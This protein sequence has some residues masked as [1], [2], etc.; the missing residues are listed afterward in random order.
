M[1]GLRGEDR[2]KGVSL[3][4]SM[5][6][7]GM[8]GEEKGDRGSRGREGGQGRQQ[9]RQGGKDQRGAMRGRRDG[10]VGCWCFT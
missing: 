9:G 10:A 5:S 4:L 6:R 2:A 7:N 3:A 1:W 8:P